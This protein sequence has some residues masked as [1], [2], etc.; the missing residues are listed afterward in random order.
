MENDDQY[1]GIFNDDEVVD[2]MLYD[3]VEKELDKKKNTGC[4][5]ALLAISGIALLGLAFLMLL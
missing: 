1:E 2:V 4:F 5:T 3:K